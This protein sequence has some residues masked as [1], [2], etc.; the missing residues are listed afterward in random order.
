ET[1]LVPTES[2]E[3]NSNDTDEKYDNSEDIVNINTNETDLL[4]ARM[5]GM[6]ENKIE[7]PCVKVKVRAFLYFL[8]EN[9]EPTFTDSFGTPFDQSIFDYSNSI[10]IA[11]S[12]LS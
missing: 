5:D 3:T 7:L 1:V 6:D 12:L 4:I 9:F 8:K 2:T 10:S 11:V